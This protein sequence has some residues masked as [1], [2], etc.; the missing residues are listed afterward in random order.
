MHS[1]IVVTISCK[2][3]CH[4]ML[5]CCHAVM[6]SCH[7]IV[8]LSQVDMLVKD[9]YGSDYAAHGLPADLIAASFGK[10]IQ[11]D[12]EQERPF[13]DEDIARSL[14]YTISNDIGQISCLYAMLHK[15]K[16][17]YFGGFFLRHHPVSIQSNSNLVLI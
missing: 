9:I 13:S 7:N 1:R 5:S 6:L 15:I 14:L 16:R 3:R 8:M 11:L 2:G 4:D 17:V 12:Q 10:T